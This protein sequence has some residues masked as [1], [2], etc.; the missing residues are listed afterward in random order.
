MSNRVEGLMLL[1]ILLLENYKAS[2]MTVFSNYN[3]VPNTL[4]ITNYSLQISLHQLSFV[5]E[6]SLDLYDQLRDTGSI[7]MAKIFHGKKVAWFVCVLS[8]FFF[9][10]GF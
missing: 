4:K 5:T 6:K 3:I 9:S 1:F 7:S 2:V 10:Y 8:L